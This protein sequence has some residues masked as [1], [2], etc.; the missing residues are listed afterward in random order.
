MEDLLP[1]IKHFPDISKKINHLF[2]EQ[3]QVISVLETTTK[4]YGTIF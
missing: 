2:L 3:N 4:R 1:K